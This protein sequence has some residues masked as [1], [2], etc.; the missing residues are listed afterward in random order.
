MRK[1][2]RYVPDYTQHDPE[3]SPM[4]AFGPTT[5]PERGSPSCRMKG[6]Q[7]QNPV[8]WIIKSAAAILARVLVIVNIHGVHSY[9][10]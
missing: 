7:H 8:F 9:G 10:N 4:A 5:P 1:S 6:L 2:N 3:H